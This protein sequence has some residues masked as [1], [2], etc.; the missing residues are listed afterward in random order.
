GAQVIGV[1]LIRDAGYALDTE[2]LL[3]RCDQRVKLVFL[4]SPNNPTGNLLSQTAILQ[5]LDALKGRAL[6]VVDEAYIE[7]SDRPSLTAHLCCHPHLA[8]L[9]TLSKAHGLAGAR[10]GALVADPEVIALLHKLIAPYAITQ[11]TAESAL[12]LLSASHLRLLHRRI[13]EVRRKRER[14]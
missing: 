11:L 7:F 1:P 4:C 5:T 8:I 6:L 3:E 10:L 9:R 13:A 2:R 14:L 12:R